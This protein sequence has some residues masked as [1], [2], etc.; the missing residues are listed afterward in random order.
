MYTFICACSHHW[1]AGSHLRGPR[2]MARQKGFLCQSAHSC[3]HRG[4]V[5]VLPRSHGVTGVFLHATVQ[6]LSGADGGHKAWTSWNGEPSDYTQPRDPHQQ[7]PANS[8]HT[9]P[10]QVRNHIVLLLLAVGGCVS[11]TDSI[12]AVYNTKNKCSSLQG[13]C[14]DWI[15]ESSFC[16]RC[17]LAYSRLFPVAYYAKAAIW[18][19]F[20]SALTGIHLET[21]LA[22]FARH[23]TKLAHNLNSCTAPSLKFW[24]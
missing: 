21:T 2:Q 10:L 3:V 8:Y 24:C 9:H 16:F 15:W 19:H 11:S 14:L 13:R 18:L 17:F 1:S 20:Q 23:K 7:S 12:S 4:C 6:R 22:I 5:R